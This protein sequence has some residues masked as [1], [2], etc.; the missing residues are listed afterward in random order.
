MARRIEGITIEFNGDTT[1]LNNAL[2]QVDKESK[3]IQKELRQVDNLLK[4]DSSN[5]EL[6]G[7][8]FQ[9]LGENVQA[10]E[11]RLDALKQAQEQ[12]TQ[13]F[14]RGDI[15]ADQYR[16]F[17][18][19][20]VAT[21]GRLE[22]LRK[23]QQATG[24]KI[25]L[26][27]DDS[28]LDRAKNK[29][30]DL[31][32]TSKEV[33]RQIG[34]NISKGASSAAK[35]V[36]GIGVAA[37]GAAVGLGAFVESNKELN[38]DLGRL[39]ANALN[40]GFSLESV[41]SAFKKVSAVSGEADSAI[42]AV[43][44]LIQTDFSEAQ[45]G[46]ALDYIN[47][48]AIRFSDTLKT[49]G[50]ADGLQETFATGEAIG[51]FGELLERSGVDLDTFNAGLAQATKNGT[52]TDYVLQQL[53]AT[54]LGDTYAEYQKNNEALLAYNDAQADSQ[55]KLAEVATALTPLVTSFLEL[56]NIILDVILGNTTLMEGFD[57]LLE[58]VTG[59]GESIFNT[60][61]E[62]IP[63]FAE[64]ITA[65]LPQILES[66]K[67]I[68]SNIITGITE[69]IPE[70]VV[71][72]YEIVTNL[73][74]TI[75]DNAPQILD[76]AVQLIQQFVGGLSRSLPKVIAAALNLV[77]TIATSI[78]RN[79]PQIISAAV[80]IIGSIIT[81]LGNALGTLVSYVTGTL[82]PR[83]IKSFDLG[84]FL[85][86]GKDIVQG[87]INGIGSLAK[88]AV[89]AI[90]KVAKGIIS[91]AKKIFRTASPSKEMFDIGDDVGQGLA[92]GIAST[93]QKN[94]AA[95]NRV[96]GII[97]SVTRENEAKVKEITTKAAE[98]RRKLDEKYNEDRKKLK[99]KDNEARVKLERDY[100]KSVTDLNKKTAE[101][102]KK[103]QET[104]Q[105]EQIAALRA[106]IKG[107]KEE[108]A[109][110]LK[111]EADYYRLSYLQFATDTKARKELQKDYAATVRSINAE[112]T[113]TNEEFT[114]RASDIEKGLQDTIKE[115]TKIYDD[116]YAKR[117]NQILGFYDLFDE[118]VKREAVSGQELITN[119]KAQ[120]DS[121]R[122]YQQVISLLGN[123]GL[124]N[125]LIEELRGLGI[126]ALDQ[127]QALN[128]LSDEELNTFDR[129]FKEK[130]A[131]A[132]SIAKEELAPLEENTRNI[133]ANAT[134]AAE[135]EL[136]KLNVEWQSRIVQVVKGTEKELSTLFQVGKDAGIGLYNG[137]GSTQGAL[138]TKARE[139]AGDISKTIKEALDINSPSRV[140]DSLG[141]FAGEGLVNGLDK[142]VNSVL[143][144]SS[145]LA[146]A[147]V[148][149]K[150]S[151]NSST[152]QSATNNVVSQ[153]INAT[154]NVNG[155]EQVLTLLAALV[156]KPMLAQLNL[157]GRTVA[158]ASFQQT[159]VLQQSQ[160]NRQALTRGL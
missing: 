130:A 48:A 57:Q 112:V 160:L 21:E 134:K 14:E 142:T 113:K 25:N 23:A 24:D 79:L 1:G 100:S 95:I 70:L 33:G 108:N 156:D 47:G 67:E 105:D 133:I 80:K 55:I 137:L 151:L 16:A 7:Q 104:L 81:G 76:T 114:K 97:L 71:K 50:I 146:G 90:G 77:I 153:Q 120:I 149:A 99:A 118:A 115:T 63:K 157:D 139:I 66:G 136:D 37:A 56:G 28:P 59:F 89:G 144:A 82:I 92:N 87:L 117:R 26:Q 154:T 110:S 18:R 74:R 109:V 3:N 152:L 61:T 10:T 91:G 65:N 41:E 35:G 101:D 122:E 72:A 43:S 145:R 111:Q 22:S 5:T 49:E 19:E 44:N 132:T 126:G 147:V 86:L 20:L 93:E 31:S 68:L 124:S 53:A 12:V 73:V 106:Y 98:E 38:M 127:L 69:T 84:E 141:Q 64:G 158:E 58:I 13:S 121:L 17:Q 102:V 83:M 128:R 119:Q 54:G 8:R 27:V 138:R 11:S 9:L 116:E 159:G 103:I 36:A 148:G 2:S 78:I 143:N 131:I 62:L 46:E 94:V 30:K 52:E 140:L 60:A 125:G 135:T 75:S 34:D 107:R 45:L 88:D 29:I 96:S 15:G 51:Q 123:R 150:S 155:L 39:E 6:L 32:E 129:Q 85:Q 4:F 40:A 42:E